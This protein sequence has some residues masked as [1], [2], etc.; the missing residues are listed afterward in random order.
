MFFTAA[1]ALAAASLAMAQDVT[2]NEASLTQCAQSTL[3]YS[4]PAGS[5]Y[6]ALV[7]AEDACSQDAIAEF[8]DVTSGSVDYAATLPAGTQVQMYVADSNSGQEY[9]GPVMT[10]ADGDAACLGGD[11]EAAPSSSTV[12]TTYIP[13]AAATTPA[14]SANTPSSGNSGNVVDNN[15]NFDTPVNAAQDTTGGAS[16]IT[17]STTLLVGAFAAAVALF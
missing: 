12:P 2:V 17:A 16:I 6:V 7:H 3:T 1:L 15:D 14:R 5:Y 13:P 11:V 8:Y 10:V 9:W 4:A